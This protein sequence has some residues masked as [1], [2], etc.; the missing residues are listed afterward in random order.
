M[1][2]G[3]VTNSLTNKMSSKTVADYYFG[4]DVSNNDSLVCRHI[5]HDIKDQYYVN[6]DK[7]E[8]KDEI[9]FYNFKLHDYDNNLLLDGL[10][11]LVALNHES[12]EENAHTGSQQQLLT[13][14]ELQAKWQTK[15]ESDASK[16]AHSI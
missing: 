1:T 3:G 15:F 5:K 14:S 2:H 7:I 6:V 13:P 11:L 8:N 9:D 10:E 12:H 4:G 16:Q